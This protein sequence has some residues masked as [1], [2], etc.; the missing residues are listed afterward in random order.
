MLGAALLYVV[1]FMLSYLL[2]FELT[3]RAGLTPAWAGAFM[4]AQ[5]A[6]MAVI[7][8]LSGAMA[9]RFGPRAPTVLG[10]AVMG[11]ALAAVATLAQ[12]PGALLVAALA[13]VGLG[14]GLYV[15]PN[16]A[17]IMGSAPRELQGTAAATAATAR[18]LGMTI[19]IAIAA[20]LHRAAGFEHSLY[21]AAALAGAGALL[22]LLRPITVRA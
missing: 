4:T 11:A 7:A 15:A 12:A 22:G 8:P 6:T 3:G 9:D 1:T 19:G 16:N 5:P 20:P 14:S 17:L 10:M 18:N 13:A 2:P 21:V